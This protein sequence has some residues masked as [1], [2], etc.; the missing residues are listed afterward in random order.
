MIKMVIVFYDW[1]GGNILFHLQKAL[2]YWIV[3]VLCSFLQ[4]KDIIVRSEL[5]SVENE[6][7][8][9]T[10]KNRRPQLR[11]FFKDDIAALY[12]KHEGFA[13]QMSMN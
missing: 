2:E 13:R 3:K 6:L 4:T 1:K 5:F 10:F 7:L 8:T 11:S 12:K 9:P